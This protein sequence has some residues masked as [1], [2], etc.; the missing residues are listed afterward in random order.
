MAIL[1]A[2]RTFRRWNLDGEL[3][4]LDAGLEASYLDL[5]SCSCSTPWL[6]MQRDQLLQV[7]DVMPSM[8]D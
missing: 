6:S 2:C 8:H 1:E 3:G 7:H 4:S 5:T